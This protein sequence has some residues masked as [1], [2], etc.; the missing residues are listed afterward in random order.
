MRKRRMP[1]EAPPD[2]LIHAV[3]AAHRRGA[4]IVGLCLGL[5]VLAA[6]GLLDG[7]RAT[8]HWR[9]AADL[10]HRYPNIQVDPDVLWV[11]HGDVVTSAGTAAVLDCC[12]HLVRQDYGTQVATRVARGWWSLPIVQD[13]KPS[14]SR[15]PWGTRRHQTPS[16]K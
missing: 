4:K 6:D 7:H 16:K 8:T 11:D 13:L 12:L 5:F 2:T 10:A 14:I 1:A 9:C 15:N 3:A